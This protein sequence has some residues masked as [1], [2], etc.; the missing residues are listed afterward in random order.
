MRFSWFENI[1]L[2]DIRVMCLYSDNIVIT[3]VPSFVWAGTF[4]NSSC[5]MF[6][7]NFLKSVQCCMLE[8]KCTVYTNVL[9]AVKIE[10]SFRYAVFSVVY[11]LPVQ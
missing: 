2:L 5:L 3:R 11:S 8:L 10:L 9:Y 1:S 4:L 6:Y 7:C